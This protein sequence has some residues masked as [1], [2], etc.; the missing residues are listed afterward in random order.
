MRLCECMVCSTSR[1]RAQKLF[2]GK[3]DGARCFNVQASTT[4]QSYVYLPAELSNGRRQHPIFF[5]VVSS[6]NFF[7]VWVHFQIRTRS[8]SG[9]RTERAFSKRAQ[10]QHARFQVAR[11][12]PV[13]SD[14]RVSQRRLSCE[15]DRMAIFTGCQRA[16]YSLMTVDG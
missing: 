12:L 11:N 3:D 5:V 13:E 8:S 16:M 9:R 14:G 15:I 2:S 4:S 6:N 7:G 10:H 1:H